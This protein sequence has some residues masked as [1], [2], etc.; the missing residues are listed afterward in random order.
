MKEV[1]N[2]FVIDQPNKLLYCPTEEGVI[3]RY[4]L[5]EYVE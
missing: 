2:G 3:Y 1:V 4:D 5:S